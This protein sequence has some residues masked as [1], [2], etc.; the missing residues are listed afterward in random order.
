MS[1][2]TVNGVDLFDG[3]NYTTHIPFNETIPTGG[4]SLTHDL[5]VH[6]DVRLYLVPSQRQK[7]TCGS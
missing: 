1:D 4:D 6:Y 3:L 5:N 2:P 7:L